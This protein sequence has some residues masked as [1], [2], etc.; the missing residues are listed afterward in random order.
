MAGDKQAAIRD[1]DTTL[2]LNI[3]YTKAYINRGLSY[4]HIAE[5][6]QAIQNYNLALKLEPRNVYAY[7]NRGCVYSHLKDYHSAIQDYSKAVEID[8]TF[9][10]AFM[11]RGL[12]KLKSGDEPGANKDFYHVMC[13]NAEAY[14][15]YQAQRGTPEGKPVA[16]QAPQ[17]D[18]SNRSKYFNTTI[19]VWDKE[20]VSQLGT[21]P[22]FLE[23]EFLDG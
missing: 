17:I 8:P 19:S 20:D 1:F 12:A 21:H 4:Y 18:Y 7:Y 5:Y 9:V 16:K 10:K 23:G 15:F 13:I 6:H 22:V 2:R 14:T 3:K 11:N